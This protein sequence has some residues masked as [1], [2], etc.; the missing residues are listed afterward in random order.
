MFTY[1]SAIRQCLP[2]TIEAMETVARRSPQLANG[3]MSMLWRY[4]TQRADGRPAEIATRVAGVVVIALVP[5]AFAVWIAY[6]VV[7]VLRTRNAI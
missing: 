4:L 5:G 2:R 6:R 3:P 7:S 1:P